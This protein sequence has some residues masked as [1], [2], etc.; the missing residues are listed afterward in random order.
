MLSI[1][2]EYWKF[3]KNTAAKAGP[4]ALPINLKRE[5]IAND[6]PL[7]CFGV[8]NIT[9]FMAPIVVNDIPIA[10]ID[11]LIPN[12]NSIEWKNRNPVNPIKLISQ[13]P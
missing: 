13:V 6:I 2:K 3:S 8:D 12:D 10:T 11:K 4:M 1:G 7:Y 5:V 9:T